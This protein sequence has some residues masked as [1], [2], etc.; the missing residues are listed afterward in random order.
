MPSLGSYCFKPKHG[1]EIAEKIIERFVN[2]FLSYEDRG[3]ALSLRRAL[4]TIKD[5]LSGDTAERL[6]AGRAVMEAD[7]VD[8][9]AIVDPSTL[10]PLNQIDGPARALVAAWIGKTR[11]IDNLEI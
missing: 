3:R 10:Q 1:P 5:H 8:Y 2:K 11:L 6:A 9:I 7:R 4:Q